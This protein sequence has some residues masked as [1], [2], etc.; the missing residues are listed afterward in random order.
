MTVAGSNRFKE[1][2]T[3]SELGKL[4]DAKLQR[5]GVESKEDRKLALEAIKK[6]GFVS[7]APT[8]SVARTAKNG[9]VMAVGGAIA[10]TEASTPGA[11]PS[12]LVGK[13][14]DYS[15]ARRFNASEVLTLWQKEKASPKPNKRKRDEDLDQDLPSGPQNETLL[16]GNL[17]FNEELNEEVLTTKATVVNRAPV[18][19]LWSTIVAER[20]GFS[21][22]EALSIGAAYTEMNAVS[23]G[24]SLG[25]F[26]ERD[27]IGMEAVKGG[28]QPYVELMG[29]R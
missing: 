6:A 25:I 26:K 4:T 1:I 15:A 11:G 13:V 18:M 20:L 5:L 24:A 3:P 8:N 23:K 27:K 21:R 12:R 22:E 29:R 28:A 14:N 10:Q 17:D 2:N 16:L 7:K 19:S 9:K